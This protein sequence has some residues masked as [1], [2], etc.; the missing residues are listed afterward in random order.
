MFS[1]VK[2][3]HDILS[4]YIVRKP[5]SAAWEHLLPVL[6]AFPDLPVPK[7]EKSSIRAYNANAGLHINGTMLVP[8]PLPS[9]FPPGVKQH[10][11]LSKHSRLREPLDVHF[12][13]R[14]HEYRTEKLY[15]IDVT[16]ISR[17]NMIDYVMKNFKNGKVGYD[18]IRVF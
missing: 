16:P 2:R 7:K 9:W 12:K 6:I 18:D 3:V 5:T 17:G 11:S 4:R 1:D 13:K 14:E 8:P 15:R 10:P